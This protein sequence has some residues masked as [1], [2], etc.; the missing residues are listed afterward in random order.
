MFFVQ[1]GAGRVYWCQI[2]FRGLERFWSS[3]RNP[4]FPSLKGLVLPNSSLIHVNT[5]APPA[6]LPAPHH[7]WAVPF[8]TSLPGFAG[9]GMRMEG[10]EKQCREEDNEK[11]F[12]GGVTSE[13]LFSSRSIY[14]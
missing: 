2:G 8:P 5:P 14:K 11:A 1:V 3:T 7:W 9:A 12:T 6:P 10:E 13:L 4:D